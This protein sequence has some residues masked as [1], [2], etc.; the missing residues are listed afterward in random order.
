M[1]CDDTVGGRETLRRLEDMV[2][3]RTKEEAEERRR[4]LRDVE[5][6]SRESRA[7]QKV[8][9]RS[10]AIGSKT[11]LMVGIALAVAIAAAPTLYFW[12]MGQPS[13]GPPSTPPPTQPPTQLEPI[14][15]LSSVEWWCDDPQSGFGLGVSFVLSEVRGVSAKVIVGWSSGFQSS[16]WGF[17]LAGHEV[18]SVD[19][20]FGIGWSCKLVGSVYI[21]SVQRA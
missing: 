10:T 1:R 5:E 8:L 9:F 6:Q 11:W 21:V 17:Q 18:R 13:A 15:Y 4:V 20:F 7:A 14:V 16:S 19:K 2:A 3:G 12:A